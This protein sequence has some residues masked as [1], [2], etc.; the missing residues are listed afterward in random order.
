MEKGRPRPARASLSSI[1]SGPGL[2]HS[3]NAPAKMQARHLLIRENPWFP[4]FVRFVSFVVKLH[5]PR[6]GIFRVRAC[7]EAVMK[8]GP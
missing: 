1:Q 8:S 3:Q 2:P 6:R 7:F 5:S 4:L